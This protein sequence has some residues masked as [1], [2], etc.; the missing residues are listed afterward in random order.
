M[1]EAGLSGRFITE[2]VRLQ[3]QYKCVFNCGGMPVVMWGPLGPVDGQE[4]AKRMQNAATVAI[5]RLESEFL[6]PVLRFHMRCFH[7]PR[8]R[9]VFGADGGAR[10]QQILNRA[11]RDIIRILGPPGEELECARVLVLEYAELAK[12]FAK[13][14]APGQPLATERNR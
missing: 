4:L 6:T 13:L 8:I 12:L 11:F 7:L 14:T 1:K 5:E 10:P 9:S 2:H 3:L